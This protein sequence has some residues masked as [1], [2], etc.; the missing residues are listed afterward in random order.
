MTLRRA[1]WIFLAGI[2]LVI[3]FVSLLPSPR[4]RNPAIPRTE[5]HRTVTVEQQCTACHA[6]GRVRPLPERHPKRKDCFRCHRRA[7][8]A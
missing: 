1:D 7:E 5:A 2:V 3:L 8:P 6:A 4:D